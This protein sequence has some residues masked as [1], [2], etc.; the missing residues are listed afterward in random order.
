[1]GLVFP[2]ARWRLGGGAAEGGGVAA[3]LLSPVTAPPGG[4]DRIP[5]RISQG[6]DCFFIFNLGT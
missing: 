4:D 3:C 1:V 6:R 5:S 2:A